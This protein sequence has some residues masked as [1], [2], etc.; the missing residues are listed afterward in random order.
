MKDL[1]HALALPAGY[2]L[3]EYEILR[4]LG[5]GGFGITYAARETT[6]GRVVAVKE[7]LPESIATRVGGS[8][9]T[10]MGPGKKDDWDWAR[11]RFY[12]EATTLAQ[13]NHPSIVGIQRLVE[14]N[15]TVYV[16][17]DF[18]DGESFGQ[19]LQACGKIASQTAL[20]NIMEPLLGGVAEVHMHGLLHRDIKPDNIIIPPH[21]APVLID[22]GSA[23][24][25]I[26][27]MTMTMTSIVSHG[28]SPIEQ[29]QT[30]GR[31]GPWTD[32]YSLG[33]VM[34][35]AITGEKPPTAADRA[36]EDGYECLGP[37]SIPGYERKFL[38][39]VDWALKS[40]PQDRPQSIESWRKAF[41]AEAVSESEPP[42]LPHTESVSQPQT[43]AVEKT[44]ANLVGLSRFAK[45][46]ALF[47]VVSILL[48][49]FGAYVSELLNSS[50]PAAP[51]IDR[52]L[53][54]TEFLVEA[55][56]VANP[57][58]G[59][60][61]VSAMPR[62]PDKRAQALKLGQLPPRFLQEGGQPLDLDDAA[63]EDFRRIP[64]W[65]SPIPA[66]QLEKVMLQRA[67]KGDVEAQFWLG[68]FYRTGDDAIKQNSQL[69][70]RWLKEAASQ[71][72]PIA[73][74]DLATM[75]RNGD[76]TIKDPAA[77]L[78]FLTAAAAEGYSPA[79]Y[80]VAEMYAQGLGAPKDQVKALGW[81]IRA[82]R[83]DYQPAVDLLKEKGISID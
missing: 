50:K 3:A 4:V 52:P 32:I 73:C 15:G 19:K 12:E 55:S 54:A 20:L 22:F 29:Y 13:F 68:S 66:K 43:I 65:I 72:D 78:M 25:T 5:V 76:G 74:Y 67:Q 26:S 56:P 6:L 61:S 33:A 16:V 44:P 63:L 70:L 39:A 38:S 40:A 14:A 21:G 2:R 60:S 17:M 11:E 41:I 28:Y 34:Y 23:R 82:A 9:V 49:V 51:L 36:L 64:D 71:G 27:Q 48:S 42:P 7:L 53:T 46:A 37:L 10:P 59:V 8:T 62:P 58:E 75:H 35:R 18:I 80:G 79:M 81:M 45:M 83:A 77:A 47:I 69:A 30:K 31:M 1:P 57:L 24:K